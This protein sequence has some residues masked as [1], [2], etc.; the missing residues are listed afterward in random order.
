MTQK[1]QKKRTAGGWIGGKFNSAGRWIKS[2][3]KSIAAG[4]AAAAAAA[5]AIYL[6]T[7]DSGDHDPPRQQQHA[8]PPPSAPEVA[9]PKK[10]QPRSAQC[11]QSVLNT[12]K[13]AP[14]GGRRSEIPLLRKCHPD[15]GGT[16]ADWLRA[17]NVATKKATRC[18]YKSRFA[19]V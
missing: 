8:P 3:W 2:H 12:F 10:N 1:G 13:N 14:C 19:S 16:D 6:G 7:K 4:A 11:S 9:P 5:G 17:T 18:G 15:K